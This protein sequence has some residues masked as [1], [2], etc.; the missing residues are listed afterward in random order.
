MRRLKMMNGNRHIKSKSRWQRHQ[1]SQIENYVGHL[2]EVN[3]VAAFPGSMLFN[4]LLVEVEKDNAPAQHGPVLVPDSLDCVYEY[5]NNGRASINMLSQSVVIDTGGID[6]IASIKTI[7]KIVSIDPEIRQ[8]VF[9][10]RSCRDSLIDHLNLQVNAVIYEPG[11]NSRFELHKIYREARHVIF[12]DNYRVMDAAFTHCSCTLIASEKFENRLSADL[13]FSS[14]QRAPYCRVFRQ[15]HL[16]ESAESEPAYGDVRDNLGSQIYQSK[17]PTFVMCE[18]NKMSLNQV[19]KLAGKPTIEDDH[20]ITPDRLLW[21]AKSLSSQAVINP[22]IAQN[23]VAGNLR[24]R[25]VAVLRKMSK[26]YSDPQAFCA[27]SKYGLLKY[28]AKLL[29]YKKKSDLEHQNQK[30][31]V[32]NKVV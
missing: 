2:H 1:Q 32:R 7:D 15:T 6:D 19:L 28:L 18:N 23:I 24:D 16:F 25:K 5:C 17:T 13:L 26:L 11:W 12:V 29:L 4:Q 9:L 30:D 27:D 20:Q 14:L 10:G 31:V 22:D 21:Y 8:V 3:V